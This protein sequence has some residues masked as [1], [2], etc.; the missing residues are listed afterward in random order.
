MVFLKYEIRVLG[1]NMDSVRFTLPADNMDQSTFLALEC[2]NGLS[3][4][5]DI[6]KLVQE[7]L[8]LGEDP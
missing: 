3:Q 8:P 4:V 5:R 2:R 1:P 6:P 7:L